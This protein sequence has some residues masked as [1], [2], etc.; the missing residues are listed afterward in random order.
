MK[1]SI[2][3]F[4]KNITRN[5]GKTVFLGGWPLSSKVCA[6]GR[7]KDLP[8]VGAMY[9]CRYRDGKRHEYGAPISE[10]NIGDPIVR[11]IFLEK[12]GIKKMSES[13]AKLYR[14]MGGESE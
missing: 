4:V 12:E 14:E 6:F 1:F 10:E 3:K 7:V 8:E 2:R 13:L 9:I 11:I 5:T